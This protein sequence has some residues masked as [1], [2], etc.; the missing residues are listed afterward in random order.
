MSCHT[1][2]E[3]PMTSIL[4]WSTWLYNGCVPVPL[5]PLKWVNIGTMYAKI[6]PKMAPHLDRIIP[7]LMLGCAAQNDPSARMDALMMNDKL[8]FSDAGTFG[9]S[10]KT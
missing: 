5:R 10:P 8:L 1:A 4:M 3:A 6:N 7:M 9:R 2:T